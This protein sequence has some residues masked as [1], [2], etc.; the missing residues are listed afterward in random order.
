MLEMICRLS[1]YLHSTKV[2][3]SHLNA[4]YSSQRF[5]RSAAYH[6]LRCW[7]LSIEVPADEK[8]NAE[9]VARRWV[10]GMQ[11]GMPMCG[12]S[13]C[14]LCLPACLPACLPGLR[15]GPLGTH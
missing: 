9:V 14:C 10:V 1:P 4:H 15:Q 7:S 11:G 6:T 5:G 8:D 3:G 2:A 13:D 12:E